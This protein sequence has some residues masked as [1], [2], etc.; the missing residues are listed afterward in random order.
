MT[1]GAEIEGAMLVTLPG[2]VQAAHGPARHR[3]GGPF[4]ARCD[5][6]QGQLSM[7][8]HCRGGRPEGDVA[9]KC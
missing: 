7:R 9:G 5:A 6:I 1:D 8:L 2:Q 3:N 4:G